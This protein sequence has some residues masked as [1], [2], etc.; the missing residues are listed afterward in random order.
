[1]KLMEDVLVEMMK[2]CV[3]WV[4]KLGNVWKY[5]MEGVMSEEN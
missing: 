4:K 5:C 3:F 1:M 2:S